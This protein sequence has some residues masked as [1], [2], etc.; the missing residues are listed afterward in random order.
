VKLFIILIILMKKKLFNLIGSSLAILAGIALTCAFAPFKVFPLAILSPALLLMLWLKAAPKRAFWYGWLFGLGFFGTGVYWIFISIH[1]YGNTS[2]FLASFI[3]GLLIAILALFPAIQGYLL[4]RL[5][6]RTN[7]ATLFCAFPAI[8]VLLEWIRTWIFTGFPWLLIGYSQINSPLKG[9]ATVFSV[10]GVSLAVLLSS[11][12]LVSIGLQLNAK[13]YKKIALQI[14]A[15]VFIWIVGFILS[16]ISWTVPSG[17]LT[18]V[19]LVQ[20]NIPQ[21]L[22]WSPEHIQPTLDH[23]Q[24]LTE[25]HWDSNIIIWPEAAV[26]LPMASATDFLS[27]MAQK[28]G[29]HHTTIITGIPMKAPDSESYYN[30]VITLGTGEGMYI[31]H[32]LVPFGEYIPLR[33]LFGKILDLMQV[34]MSDFIPDEK[35]PKPIIAHGKKIATFICYEIAFPEQVLSNDDH[36]DMILTVSNDAWFGHSIAQDQ[37]IEMAQMRAIEMGRPVL[38]VAND[39][40]TGIINA[41]GMIQSAAPPHESYVLTDTV[42][43][44]EGKTPWQRFGIFPISALIII[45][46]V[47]AIRRR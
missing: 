40:I 9:Y 42:Q 44:T 15:F 8:W 11:A 30:A 41:Q 28:A 12:L 27:L 29:E 3:T 39:G 35:E 34:P 45:L 25:A 2:V 21:D 17:E 31:K 36:I 19:S 6:P 26:P 14:T 38:F 22:K 47:I 23:Y 1:T 7:N 13:H 4:S 20:G 24:E 16:S 5:F 33:Q 10:Y 32:R 46:L 37:H 18:K 43:T